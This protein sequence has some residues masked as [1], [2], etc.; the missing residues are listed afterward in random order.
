MENT[1]FSKKGC[2]VQKT[3]CPYLILAFFDCAF[4]IAVILL[5]VVLHYNFGMW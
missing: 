5:I 2:L 3:G 4:S 1:V